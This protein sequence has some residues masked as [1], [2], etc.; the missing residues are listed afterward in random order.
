MASSPNR[1]PASAIS[2]PC[3][4]LAAGR[5][6]VAAPPLDGSK[7]L[8]PALARVHPWLE[9]AAMLAIGALALFWA[10]QH[11]QLMLGVFMAIGTLG[12]LRQGP[13]RPFASPLTPGQGLAAFGAY[14]AAVVLCALAVDVASNGAVL[15]WIGR[16]G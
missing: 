5:A 14:L 6:G 1:G 10:I 2:T 15:R 8:G 3:I 12:A 11:R 13:L 16:Q 9:R 7:A 4:S